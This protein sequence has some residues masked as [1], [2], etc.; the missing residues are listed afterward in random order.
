MN[1]QALLAQ[2]Q[3]DEK[4][5]AAYYRLV[6]QEQPGVFR[7]RMMTDRL[8]DEE[9]NATKGMIPEAA[10]AAVYPE[11]ISLQAWRDAWTPADPQQAQMDELVA[12][13]SDV[14]DD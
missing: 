4:C 8:T 2:R 1:I 12:E 7:V 10:F 9:K 14:D 6:Q 5:D 11:Y 13:Y 3:D